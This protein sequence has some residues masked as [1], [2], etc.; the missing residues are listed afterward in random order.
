MAWPVQHDEEFRGDGEMQRP[1]GLRGWP[2]QTIVHVAVSG[3]GAAPNFSAHRS[4]MFLPCAKISNCASRTQQTRF[5]VLATSISRP[6][7]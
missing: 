4:R 7:D 3:P 5:Q 6:Q 2:S 1:A